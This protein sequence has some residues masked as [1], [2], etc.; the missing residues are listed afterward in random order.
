MIRADQ[1]PDDVVEAA[2]KAIYEHWQ[3]AAQFGP[4]AP[5]W[6][7]GGNSLKQDEARSYARVS[8]LAILNLWPGRTEYAGFDADDTL[9][10][11]ITLP[12]EVK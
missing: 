4:K 3:F 6:I 5:P 7:T 11:T 12:M 9:R 10:H 2:A 8:C 1:I